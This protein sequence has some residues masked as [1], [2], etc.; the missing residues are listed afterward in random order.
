M[1]EVLEE[2]AFKMLL[3]QLSNARP[4]TSSDKVETIQKSPYFKW[5]VMFEN[6]CHQELMPIFIS[7][8]WIQGHITH[9]FDESGNK[10]LLVDD[11]TGVALVS[12]LSHL[13]QSSLSCFKLGC[14]VMVIGHVVGV[15]VNLPIVE[16]LVNAKIKAI[17][18]VNISQ[19]SNCRTGKC[20]MCEV[21]DAQNH[22]ASCQTV[23]N[24]LSSP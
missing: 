1:T 2:P 21:K 20:W 18:L 13:P 7:N 3:K 17:K 9:V 23:N 10:A 4:V 19:H 16:R 5:V 14:L 6:P 22:I 8:I 15:N 12:G 24:K 11:H